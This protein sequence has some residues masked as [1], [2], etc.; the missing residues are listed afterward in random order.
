ME[1]FSPSAVDEVSG[2]SALS[3][4][5]EADQ[6]VYLWRTSSEWRGCRELVVTFTTGQ[7][8]SAVFRFS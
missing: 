4:D 1:G 5:A 8:L 6:Y 2:P 7:S 3:Y